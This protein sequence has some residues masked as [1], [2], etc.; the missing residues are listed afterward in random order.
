M[1]PWV[2][3]FEALGT[4]KVVRVGANEV[5]D[6]TASPFFNDDDDDG[7]DDDDIPGAEHWAL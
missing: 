6:A 5:S 3:S 1:P 2:V 4:L 7:D